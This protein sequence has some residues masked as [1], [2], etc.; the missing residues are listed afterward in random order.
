M[1]NNN[2]LGKNIKCL[3]NFFGETQSDLGK[4]LNLEKNTISEYENGKRTPITETMVKI[5]EHYGISVEVMMHSDLSPMV[6]MMKNTPFIEN[7]VGPNSY[8]FYPSFVS[9]DCLDTGNDHLNKAYNKIRYIK[10]NLGNYEEIST[11]IFC[12]TLMELITASNEEN[13]CNMEIHAN[14]LWTIFMWWSAFVDI[15]IQRNIKQKIMLKKIKASDLLGID[16]KNSAVMNNKRVDFLKTNEIYINTAIKILKS[17]EEWA[18]LGDYYIAFRYLTNMV[19]T[20]FPANLN[21]TIGQEMM[22]SCIKMG[23]K[24]AINILSYFMDNQNPFN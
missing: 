3:R 15:E 10:R 22:L 12:D 21:R 4:I 7:L 23:N 20:D 16:E 24:Y 9:E 6:K 8:I 5:A 18:D 2:L 17:R 1:D 11:T 19:D 13:G 14:I